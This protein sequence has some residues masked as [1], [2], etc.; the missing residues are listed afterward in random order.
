MEI[1]S[2]LNP[3]SEKN[4]IRKT[5]KQELRKWISEIEGKA[6]RVGASEWSRGDASDIDGQNR[7]VEWAGA[8]ESMRATSEFQS[9]KAGKQESRK[10]GKQESRKAG[11]Q[12]SRKA[13]KQESRKAGMSDIPA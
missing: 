7:E 13:G 8:H 6:T 3:N 5:G 12:E 1:E 10:A 2:H 11:K 4:L 9:R